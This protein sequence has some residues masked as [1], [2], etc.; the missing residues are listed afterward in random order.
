MAIC[1]PDCVLLL[2]SRLSAVLSQ[3]KAQSI[4]AR[5]EFILAI[6]HHFE[7]AIYRLF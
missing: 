7:Y 3:K 6:K 1:R 2:L 5:R 4:S